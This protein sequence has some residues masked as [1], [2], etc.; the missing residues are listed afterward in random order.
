MENH[1]VDPLGG[2][3][4]RAFDRSPELQ[5][6]PEFI[7]GLAGLRD[8]QPAPATR[9]RTRPR[10]LAVAAT[11]VL[12]TAGGYWSFE[13]RLSADPLRE[14]VIGDHR[15]CALGVATGGRQATGI[16]PLAK[17]A[18]QY[19]RGFHVLE[20]APADDVPTSGGTA[21]VLNRHSCVFG[22]RRFAHIIL[23]YRGTPVSLIVTR[24]GATASS[25]NATA[26]DTLTTAV[27][28]DLTIMSVHT[29]EY[30]VYV[31]GSLPA[32]ELSPLANAL[33]ADLLSALSKS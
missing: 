23:Q 16:L 19:E 22:G 31:V 3:L 7:A 18:D 26:A 4:R 13:A 32:S 14:T 20:N 21:R 15:Y 5:P 29:P 1:E 28:K 25:V 33:S 6:A 30:S 9:P 11:L 8:L 27:A 10:W 17:A 12:V 2:A 24:G